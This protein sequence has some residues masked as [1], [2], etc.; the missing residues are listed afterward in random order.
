MKKLLL[1]G[2]ILSLQ[3][4]A[5]YGLTDDSGKLSKEQKAMIVATADFN[6]KQPNK[7]YAINGKA[8]RAELQKYPKSLVYVFTNGCGAESCKPL[9]TY[10]NYARKNNIKLFLVMN[11]YGNLDYTLA[12]PHPEPL[13]A[14]DNDYYNCTFRGTYTRHFENDLTGKP[15][16]QKNTEGWQGSLYLFDY[17][18]LEKTLIDLP[19][20]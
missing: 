14:I 15:T 19:L 2:A 18:Q 10:D 3:G 7:I 9:M 1:I 6:A 16:R 8:L 11:G 20:E 12:V 5:I 4:C 13:Y 17:G